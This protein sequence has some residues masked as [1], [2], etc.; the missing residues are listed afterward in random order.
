ME[1]KNVQ[2]FLSISQRFS[3]AE[4]E[5]IDVYPEN[6][7]DFFKYLSNPKISQKDKAMTLHNLM[8]KVKENR[9]ISEYFSKYEGQSIYIFLFKLYIDQSSTDI[10]RVAIL[11]LINELR[12]NIEADKN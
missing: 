2:P 7:N 6:I 9:T 4:V 11:N 3:E 5:D 10:I 12:I 8:I 1:Q